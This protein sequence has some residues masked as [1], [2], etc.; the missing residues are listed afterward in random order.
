MIAVGEL[1]KLLQFMH[2]FV[3]ARTCKNTLFSLRSCREMWKL[4][5]EAIVAR[6]CFMNLDKLRKEF[7]F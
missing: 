3:F 1:P 7:D 6:R 5:S 2:N 4:K